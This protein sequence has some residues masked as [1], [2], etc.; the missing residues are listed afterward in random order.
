MSF[1]GT[2]LIEDPRVHATWKYG[3]EGRQM[4][5]HSTVVCGLRGLSSRM[6]RTEIIPVRA[7]GHAQVKS[8]G[9]GRSG[10]V[11]SR[12][13]EIVPEDIHAVRLRLLW[14]AGD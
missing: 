11:A 1:R 7:N 14:D 6:L 8:S 2:Q 4:D 9:S 12:S 13:F 10:T 3:S 5:T